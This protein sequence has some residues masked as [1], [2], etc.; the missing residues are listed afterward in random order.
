MTDG[1]LAIVQAIRDPRVRVLADG[2]N[3]GLPARLN[4]QMQ[5]ARGEFYARFDADDLMHPTRLARQVEF[6]DAHPEYSLID[7]G[8]YA[9][10]AENTIHGKRFC[11][12]LDY[13]PQIMIERGI[14][15]H[16]AALGRVAWF[17][18]HPYD[19]TFHRA[20]DH[21]LWCRTCHET[22]FARITEPLYF[23]REI[24]IPT[25]WKYLETWQK[26]RR[27][28][29]RYGRD[30]AGQWTSTLVDWKTWGKSLVWALAV[31]CRQE[32]RIIRR[33]SLP[34]TPDE[35]AVASAVLTSLLHVPL[36][37]IDDQ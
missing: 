9:I 22:R 12:P 10:D 32:H 29:R 34:I 20:E 16:S 3:L 19:P 6:L 4:Q 30:I 17:R 35:Q 7:T 14:M 15:N 37:G 27:I 8:M 36:P 31:L 25:L 2:R 23:Y 5:L 21:E 13:R 28:I 26:D 1:S 33:R 24:G 18:D 11:E